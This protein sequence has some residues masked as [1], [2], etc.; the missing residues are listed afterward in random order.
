MFYEK[1]FLKLKVW[2]STFESKVLFC[3]GAFGDFFLGLDIAMKYNLP[4]IYWSKPYTLDLSHKFLRAFD[5]KYYVINVGKEIWRDIN[6]HEFCNHIREE[7]KDR[8]FR[9]HGNNKCHLPYLGFKPD[10][11]NKQYAKFQNYKLNLPEKYVLFCPSGSTGEKRIKKFF[12]QNEFNIIAQ[13]LKEKKIEP[14]IVGSENQFKKYDSHKRYRWLEFEKFEGKNISVNHFIEAVRCCS[15]VISPDTSIKT[16]SAAMH[17]PTYVLRTRNQENN[18]I[19]I[20]WDVIFLDKNKWKTIE[21]FTFNEIV[22]R[23]YGQNKIKML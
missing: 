10:I 7:I 11:I 21:R 4:I 18:Y 12:S 8:G 1:E 19:N 14:I 16:L 15:F 3:S 2:L 23:L 13:M 22:Q 17:I 20:G 9:T 5:L 6:T